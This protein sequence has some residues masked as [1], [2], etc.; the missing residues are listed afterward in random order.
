MNLID[1]TKN[2]VA[3]TS[4]IEFPRDAL[5]VTTNTFGR[6]SY[7]ASFPIFGA[8]SGNTIATHAKIDKQSF[9]KCKLSI[10]KTINIPDIRCLEICNTFCDSNLILNTTKPHSIKII[11]NTKNTHQNNKIQTEPPNQAYHIT[12]RDDTN[13]LNLYINNIINNHDCSL[14]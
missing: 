10:E 14:N 4:S 6:L 8:S 1:N 7:T 9:K 3:L 12:E 13:D 2:I 5:T 11:E